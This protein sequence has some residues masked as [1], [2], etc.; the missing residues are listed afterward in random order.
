[1][2]DPLLRNRIRGRRA[3]APILLAASLICLTISTRSLV[4]VPERIGITVFG[5]FQKGFSV[6]AAFFSDTITSIAELRRLRHDY[7]ELAEKLQRFTEIE[8]GLADMRAEN[9]RLKDQLQL[10]EGIVYE[11][12]AARIVAKDPGNLFSSIVIDKGVERGIRK[13]MPVVALQD[14]IEGLV[15]R[16]VEVGRG[17]SIIVPLYDTSSHVACRLVNTRHEGLVGGTGSIDDPLV[18]RF[19]KKRAKDEVQFGDLVS[20][21]GYESIYPP[22]IAVGRVTKIHVLEYQTSIE[23]DLDPVLDFSRVE[24]VFAIKP[25]ASAIGQDGG[26]QQ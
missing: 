5:F 4:G 6:V 11:R 18:M 1:V 15:G 12:V 17:T 23:I 3:V 24:Y 26:S 10:S 9:A 22:D 13:N 8:R 19:V 21:T 7:E 2:P 14:G 25:V 16:V 20:T